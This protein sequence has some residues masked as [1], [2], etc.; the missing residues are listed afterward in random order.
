MGN[1]MDGRR[2]SPRVNREGWEMAGAASM[3]P[4]SFLAFVS[5][6]QWEA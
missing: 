5:L 1:K 6:A 3:L 4:V 2:E